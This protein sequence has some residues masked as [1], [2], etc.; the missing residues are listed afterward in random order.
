[1]ALS[2]TLI[3]PLPCKPI[4]PSSTRNETVIFSAPRLRDNHYT[5]SNS[6]WFRLRSRYLEVVGARKN[7]CTRG[8]HACLPLARPF[9]LVPTTSK[10]LLRRIILLKSKVTPQRYA[11]DASEKPLEVIS[12]TTCE[13]TVS[14][15]VNTNQDRAK[16]GFVS[17]REWELPHKSLFSL[18]PLETNPPLGRCYIVTTLLRSL[19]GW[20]HAMLSTHTRIGSNS[21]RSLGITWSLPLGKPYPTKR[22]N[23]ACTIIVLWYNRTREK[24]P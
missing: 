2:R 14:F 4:I 13:R 16:G 22:Q 15:A 3:Y 8:R 7:R 23:R 19:S 6:F 9:F 1:M 24:M 12:V 20:S 17:P 11:Y 10:R 5:R 18:K 21:S